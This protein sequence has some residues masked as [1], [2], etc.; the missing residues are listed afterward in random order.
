MPLFPRQ[1]GARQNPASP[2]P[3]I[4]LRPS[5]VRIE[6]NSRPA[7]FHRRHVPRTKIVSGSIWIR[8]LIVC[9][10]RV[11]L[12]NALG[13]SDSEI[14]DIRP[15]NMFCFVGPSGD[16]KGAAVTG[17]R[18]AVGVGRRGI[19]SIHTLQNDFQYLPQAPRITFSSGTTANPPTCFSSSFYSPPP[20][21]D[22]VSRDSRRDRGLDPFVRARIVCE[23]GVF[24]TS[25]TPHNVHSLC[26][27]LSGSRPV[28][29]S[30]SP[31]PAHQSV[32]G[33]G[34]F[35][36]VASVLL[37]D[38]KTLD[39]TQRNGPIGYHRRNTAGSC[40]RN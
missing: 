35:A 22:R 13:F 25:R 36:L 7:I 16:N 31:T 37:P 29:L 40:A 8:R 4:V 5:L 27:C 19:G 2:R 11:R 3:V 28:K 21:G 12:G 14:D 17:V 23:S 30:V 24:L 33:N 15:K 26:G 39:E 32:A 18:D 38:E 6:R 9:V 10:G 1:R 20:L 34:R